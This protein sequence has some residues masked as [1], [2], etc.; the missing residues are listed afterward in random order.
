[1]DNYY[2]INSYI[3]GKFVSSSE[4]FYDKNKIKEVKNILD[5]NSNTNNIIFGNYLP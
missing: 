2:I 4:I 5:E 1:M 3:G